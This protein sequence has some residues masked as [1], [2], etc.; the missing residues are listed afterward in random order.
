MRKFFVVSIYGART[1]DYEVMRFKI[2]DPGGGQVMKNI[3]RV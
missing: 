3:F 1:V 2:R